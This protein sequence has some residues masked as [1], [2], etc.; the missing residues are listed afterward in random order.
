MGEA[1]YLMTDRE[2]LRSM[3]A[4]QA[5]FH[6]P[7]VVL[8]GLTAE[9]ATARPPGAPH[10]IAE[11]VAHMW[12]WQD[13]FNRVA[14]EGFRGFPEH[15][16]EGWPAVAAGEWDELRTR[17]LTAVQ[18]TQQ[19]ALTCGRLDEKLLPADFPVPFWQR[20]TVGSGLLH[21]AVHSSHHLGQVVT[22]RQVMGLW[23][24]P[25]GSMTW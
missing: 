17:F 24:P 3:A 7:A 23:P 9:Q 2:L 15:A 13:F 20:E 6:A 10:S 12:Y 18:L 4:F 5:G 11:I 14:R 16:D 22:L 19:L 21:G 1:L 25:A 8:E